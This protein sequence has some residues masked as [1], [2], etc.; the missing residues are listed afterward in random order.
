M[1]G[2]KLTIKIKSNFII[3]LKK[4]QFDIQHFNY[5]RNEKEYDADPGKKYPRMD[6]DIFFKQK[7]VYDGTCTQGAA[8]YNP[9][10]PIAME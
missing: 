10:Y 3:I 9:D 7:M 2:I 4:F 5:T 8:K 1:V 6:M